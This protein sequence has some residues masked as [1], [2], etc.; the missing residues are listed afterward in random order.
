MTHRSPDADRDHHQQDEDVD[1][2]VFDAQRTPM[3][4]RREP[5]PLGRAG[6]GQ[7]Q[8]SLPHAFA[9]RC[10]RQRPSSHGY[11]YSSAPT[12]NVTNS[13]ADTQCLSRK[14]RTCSTDLNSQ[15]TEIKS[16][17]ERPRPVPTSSAV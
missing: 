1:R 11:P 2:Q 16:S 4:D 7:S 3:A 12:R 8:N 6:G 9:W 17:S 5:V 13:A 14:K 10:R 15:N